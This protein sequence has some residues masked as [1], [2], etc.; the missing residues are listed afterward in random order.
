MSWNSFFAISSLS[1]GNRR[2]LA[3]IG[4]PVVDMCSLTPWAGRFL[5]NAGVVRTGL[6]CSSLLNLFVCAPT[7]EMRGISRAGFP[8]IME[9]SSCRTKHW[10]FISTS[11][12]CFRRKSAPSIL[13]RTS[14]MTN[15]HWYLRSRR[16]MVKDRSPYERMEDPLAAVRGGPRRPDLWSDLEAGMREMSAP[17]STRKFLPEISSLTYN[18]VDVTTGL[19]AQADRALSFPGRMNRGI[20]ISRLTYRTVDGNSSSLRWVVV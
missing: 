20:C 14:A 10:F 5:W 12:P 19:G 6:F 15:L 18:V 9:R 7:F 17:L 16:W 2:A 13:W 1:G 3:W 4:G 8:R 11:N